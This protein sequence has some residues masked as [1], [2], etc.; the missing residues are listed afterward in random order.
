MGLNDLLCFP[1][2]PISLKNNRGRNI[3]KTL[4]LIRRY[5]SFTSLTD[6][7]LLKASLMELA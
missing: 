1:F 2:L 6:V 5:F 7:T 4:L 3:P